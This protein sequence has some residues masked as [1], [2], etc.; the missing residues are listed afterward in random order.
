MNGTLDIHHI[1]ND[2]FNDDPSNLVEL[3]HSKHLKLHGSL[4]GYFNWVYS[5]PPGN[6]YQTR[7]YKKK[8]I[9]WWLKNKIILF[10]RF[11]NAYLVP[12]IHKGI[13]RKLLID[14]ANQKQY[15]GLNK[16]EKICPPT[17]HSF[18][19]NTCSFDRC[20]QMQS[21]EPREQPEEP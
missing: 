12:V 11:Q 1:D 8:I 2:H 15:V 6:Y 7:G 9:T 16:P 13:N 17:Q 3:S 20:G 18:C 4:T 10:S 21:V 5:I 14:G 19:F